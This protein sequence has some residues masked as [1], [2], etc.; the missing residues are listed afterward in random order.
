MS[1]ASR[2]WKAVEMTDL[3]G[4]THTLVVTGEVEVHKANETPKLVKAHPQGISPATLILTLSVDGA[5]DTGP[6]VMQWKR[7]KFSTEIMSRQYKHVM[8]TGATDEQTVE[9]E[10][11]LS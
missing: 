2:N 1:Y 11:I 7:V 10:E 3:V 8:I 6:D 5:G 4:S 9:V